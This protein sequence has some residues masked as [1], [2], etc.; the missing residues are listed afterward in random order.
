VPLAVQVRGEGVDTEC[1]GEQD[2]GLAEVADPVCA[3]QPDGV[4]EVALNAPGVVA[5]VAPFEVRVPGWDRG[6]ANDRFLDVSIP[7]LKN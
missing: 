1:V 2:Q 3:A 5:A 7:K 4:V 6:D